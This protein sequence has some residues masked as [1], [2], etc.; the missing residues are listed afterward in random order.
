MISSTKSHLLRVAMMTGIFEDGRHQRVYYASCTIQHLSKWRHL[1][2]TRRQS[3]RN[4]RLST[5]KLMCHI[6]QYI[7]R[8]GAP[9]CNPR[10]LIFAAVNVQDQALIGLF[11]SL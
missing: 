5:C 2:V 9:G 3:N 4:G 10:N 7:S 1:P 6:K 11:F 8:G